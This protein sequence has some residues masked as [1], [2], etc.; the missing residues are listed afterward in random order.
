MCPA[1]GI[2]AT[3]LLGVGVF[4]ALFAQFARALSRDPDDGED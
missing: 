1:A 4:V 2:W 3:D